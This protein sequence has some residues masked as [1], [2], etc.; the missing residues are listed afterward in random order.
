MILGA[1]GAYVCTV[2]VEQGSGGIIAKAME[3]ERRANAAL[4]VHCVNSYEI[5]K[6]VL[7]EIAGDPTDLSSD[8]ANLA[9]AVLST[10][11]K[12]PE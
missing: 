9:R 4:I 6:A 10:I 3:G 1:S 11:Q 8:Q 5:M 12:A 2:Q 7:E